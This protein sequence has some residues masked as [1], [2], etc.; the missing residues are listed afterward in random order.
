MHLA[1]RLIRLIAG[2]DLSA[3]DD[4]RFDRRPY[5]RPPFFDMPGFFNNPSKLLNKFFVIFILNYN[6]YT[7]PPSATVY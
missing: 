7:F 3:T 4:V 2:K 6:L 1:F 5:S